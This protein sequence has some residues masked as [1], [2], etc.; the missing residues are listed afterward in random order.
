[1]LFILLSKYFLI[2]F[3]L[4]CVSFITTDNVHVCIIYCQ[5]ALM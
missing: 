2:F 1:M 5:E 4:V 3:Y